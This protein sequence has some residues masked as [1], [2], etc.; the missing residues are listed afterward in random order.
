MSIDN[1][2]LISVKEACKLTPYSVEYLGLLLR[3]KRVEGVKLGGRWM[4]TPKAVEFYLKKTAES[5]YEHQQNLKVKIPA[6]EIK[7][8]ATNLRWSLALLT[9]IILT[10]LTIWKIMDDN[11]NANIRNEFTIVKDNENNLIIYA[12]HPDDIKS[13]KVEQK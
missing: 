3:K 8:A 11:R 13:V 4:T 7:K 5:S 6:E 2:D 12:D 10:G 9:F 1:Q